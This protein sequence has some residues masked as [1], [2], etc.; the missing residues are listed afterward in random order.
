MQCCTTVYRAATLVWTS[1]APGRGCCN[2]CPSRMHSSHWQLLSVKTGSAPS[3]P[4][5]KALSSPQWHSRVLCCSS[6]R[7]EIT[8]APPLG[9]RSGRLPLSTVLT[10]NCP[11][12]AGGPCL[13]NS[14][15]PHYKLR[16]LPCVAHSSLSFSHAEG[17]QCYGCTQPCVRGRQ[18]R[19]SVH[20]AI[21]F[22]TSSPFSTGLL[23]L[24]WFKE[25]IWV[26]SDE[27]LT[28]H[29][30]CFNLHTFPSCFTECCCS[31]I[32]YTLID[33]SIYPCHT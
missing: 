7:P 10:L 28:L 27:V 3:H 5:Q 23:F 31:N 12:A 25:I 24:Q 13:F 29:L 32:D 15:L 11:I 30:T 16:D 4:L 33:Y 2:P 21:G 19:S 22:S 14:P 20:L 17:L 18:S 8:P 6:E 26:A 1:Q 9:H